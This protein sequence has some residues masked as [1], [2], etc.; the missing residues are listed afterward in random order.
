[1]YL[2]TITII[3]AE[4]GQEKAKIGGLTRLNCQMPRSL[5]SAKVS[6]Y[7]TNTISNV[8]NSIV[9]FVEMD[10]RIPII[11]VSTTINCHR[12]TVSVTRKSVSNP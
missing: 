4:Y 9:G 2:N 3:T 5:S 1:M 10:H 6:L 11:G 8:T 7:S 12:S